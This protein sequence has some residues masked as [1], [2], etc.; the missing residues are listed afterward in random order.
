MR[1]S[2]TVSLNKQLIAMGILGGTVYCG[3]SY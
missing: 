3:A 1:P 2:I